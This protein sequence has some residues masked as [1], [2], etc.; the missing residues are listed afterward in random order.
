MFITAALSLRATPLSCALHKLRLRLSLMVEAPLSRRAAHKSK[1]LNRRVADALILF[2]NNTRDNM[3]YLDIVKAYLKD[4]CLDEPKKLSKLIGTCGAILGFWGISGGFPLSKINKFLSKSSREASYVDF[5]I[6]KKAGGVRKI[7]APVESLKQ[8]QQSLNLLLQAL[9]EV[10]PEATG[11]VPG[12]SIV[13]N[14]TAHLGSSVVFNCDLENFFPSITIEMVH[15]TLNGELKC[16]KPSCR[17]LSIL[18]R[19]M[20]VPRTDGVEALPQGAPT[21]PYISNLILKPLDKRLS[22]FA[23]NNGYRYTR[24]ADDIT[25]SRAGSFNPCF[26]MK[27]D[28]ILSIIEDF[29][30]NVNH[31]KTRL[32]FSSGH[33]EVTGLSFGM[34]VNVSR[35]YIKQLRILLHLWESRGYREAQTIYMRDFVGG[36]DTKLASV[37]NGK[38]NYLRMVKGPDDTTYLHFKYRYRNLINQLKSM[39]K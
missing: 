27:T 31:K 7:S 8:I 20:T 10:S 28:T 5:E 15:R 34:K 3:P 21:S 23:E 36:N 14:A 16:Y 30:L 26:P 39:D 33:M 19:L 4:I 2:F 25:F 35:R 1:A 6:P 13:T 22:K 37:I 38:I 29:G 12:R 18:S 24:Y 9:C 11:F 32:S 17:V